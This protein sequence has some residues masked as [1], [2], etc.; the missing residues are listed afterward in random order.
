MA[1]REIGK[2]KFILKLKKHGA[3]RKSYQPYRSR[4]VGVW[5]MP[6]KWI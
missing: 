4:L 2:E 6:G 5:G 1:K 3:A